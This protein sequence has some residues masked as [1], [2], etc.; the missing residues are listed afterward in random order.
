M[1]HKRLFTSV[2]PVVEL[3]EHMHSTAIVREK[4][5]NRPKQDT[6]GFV[7]ETGEENEKPISRQSSK[8]TDILA[9]SAKRWIRDRSSDDRDI[10]KKVNFSSQPNAKQV[11]YQLKTKQTPEATSKEFEK[12]KPTRRTELIYGKTIS[13]KSRKRETAE[14]LKQSLDLSPAPLD[15]PKKLLQ[16]GASPRFRSVSVPP[17]SGQTHSISTIVK[18]RTMAMKWRGKTGR[19]GRRHTVLPTLADDSTKISLCA[20]V[21]CSPQ[22]E[23]VI[24]LLEDDEE[25]DDANKSLQ[26]LNLK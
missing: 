3:N 25:V 9:F 8:S 1:P 4:V 14:T 24:K 7:L 23:E 22:F 6:N 13:S 21:K 17:D 15:F 10:L 18:A 19:M 5:L 11:F 16:E 2:D 12:T 26:L 20:N